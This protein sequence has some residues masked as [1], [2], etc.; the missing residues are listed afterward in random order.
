MNKKLVLKTILLFFVLCIKLN[1]QIST[2][3]IPISFNYNLSNE[4]IPT[5]IMPAINLEQLQIED[6]AEELLGITT[7]TLQKKVNLFFNL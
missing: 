5:L 2:R 1:A 6:E 7:S 4:L 3:E